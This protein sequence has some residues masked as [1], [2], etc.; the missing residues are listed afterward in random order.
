MSPILTELRP[1]SPSLRKVGDLGDSCDNICQLLHPYRSPP[2]SL[3][4]LKRLLKLSHDHK[5]PS[6]CSFIFSVSNGTAS[7]SCLTLLFKLV[8]PLKSDL[9][10]ELLEKG[11]VR[12]WLQA[13]KISANGKVD[14]VFN[15][16][17]LS[18]GD[19]SEWKIRE[20]L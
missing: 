9:A 19:V 13:D 7:L 18:Q 16:C 11:R 3:S 17:S 20:P 8:I 1:A 4:E 15:E 12:F 6:E 2:L 10:V 14:Y 5:F